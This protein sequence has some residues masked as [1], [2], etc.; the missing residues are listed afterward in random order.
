MNYLA[1]DLLYDFQC[2][3]DACPNT[4]CV[5]WVISIDEETHQKMVENE[6]RLGVAADDWLEK[7]EKGSL[8]KMDNGRCPMLNE[9]NLCNVV[10]ILGPE[11]LSNTCTC[12]PRVM[13]QYGSVIEG[14]FKVSCPEIIREL[15]E[16]TNVQFELNEDERPAS[17][18]SHTKLYL[19]E[20]AVRNSI[21]SIL[22]RSLDI[23]LCTRLFVSYN[24]L[25]EAIRHYK[26][27][28]FDFNMLRKDIEECMQE[29]VLL[30]M[31]AN[32]HGIIQERE[33]YSFL[34]QF[35]MVLLDFSGQERFKKMV[36]QVNAYFLRNDFEQYL[37]D[38]H[39][40]RVCLRQYDNFY[41][42]YWVC[43]IFSEIIVIPAYEKARDE[44]IYITAEF[45]LFQIVAFV[46]YVNNGT[47]DREEYIYA[48]S[49]VSRRMEHNSNFHEKLMAQLKENEVDDIVG[50]LMMTITA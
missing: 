23:S 20:S 24:I 7:K 13:S 49:C 10:L 47:L 1:I 4:C 44:F 45:C 50:L 15:M 11:Y 5:G 28:Q 43:R 16:K 36:Q 29:E 48:I 6:D 21:I 2:I 17:P 27:K 9:K 46:L 3:A 33:Q 14:H 38:M 35:Q 37:A 12:Y 8:V 19:Y 41:I 25:D 42:N 30:S 39:R 34:Q 32:M 18:Y 40:F 26:E 22:Q 31:N